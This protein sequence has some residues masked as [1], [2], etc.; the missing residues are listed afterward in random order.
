MTSVSR[1][2]LALGL[3]SLTACGG[4]YSSSTGS[5]PSPVPDMS[6]TPPS[7][8][9]RVGLRAGWM[10]A[11]EA[12]W[13]LRVVSKT[14][15]SEKFINPSTPGDRRLTNSDLSFTGTYAIQGNYSG[16]QVWNISNPRQPTLRKAYVCPG[17]QSDVS[18][19]RNLLFVSGEAFNEIGRAHV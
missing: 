7:P 4:S 9:P 14:P 17:S 12:I 10:S 19:Y 11:A 16:W 6:L 8:D 5:A 3:L 1:L 18:V 2:S 13:N 15:P